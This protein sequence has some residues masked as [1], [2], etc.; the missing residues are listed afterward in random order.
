VGAWQG[1]PQVGAGGRSEF[2]KRKTVNTKYMHRGIHRWGGG[3]EGGVSRGGTTSGGGGGG[4]FEFD[5]RKTVNT[6]YIQYTKTT[7]AI[8][9]GS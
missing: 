3:G 5:K 6:K 7:T 1:Q 9:K 2:D 4:R 8:G